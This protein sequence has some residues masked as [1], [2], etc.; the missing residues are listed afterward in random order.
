MWWQRKLISGVCISVSKGRSV[1]SQNKCSKSRVFRSPNH[2]LCYWSVSVKNIIVITINKY[3]QDPLPKVWIA[4]ETVF[5]MLEYHKTVK[6]SSSWW[7]IRKNLIE[8]LIEILWDI[9]NIWKIKITFQLKRCS[10]Y[11][12]IPKLIIYLLGYI[13]LVPSQAISE[14]I[15]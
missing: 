14:S 1:H 2:L 10:I 9:L 8:R 4:R 12:G 11:C 3:F 7:Q 13:E 6:T 15:S 5:H